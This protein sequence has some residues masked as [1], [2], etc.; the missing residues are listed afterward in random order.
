MIDT[1][2]LVL[3]PQ[4]AASLFALAQKVPVWIVSTPENVAAVRRLRPSLPAEQLTTILKFPGESDDDLVVRSAFDID[5]HYGET[6][7]PTPYTVLWV[8]G[9]NDSTLASQLMENLAFSSVEM[10]DDGFKVIR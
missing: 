10:T 2:A 7:Q 5:S 4:F 6:S 8:I 1:V 3:E 9:S